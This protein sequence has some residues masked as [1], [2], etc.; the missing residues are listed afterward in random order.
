MVCNSAV[1]GLAPFSA[2][3]DV[4]WFFVALFWYCSECLAAFLCATHIFGVLFVSFHGMKAMTTDGMGKR[5]IYPSTNLELW[6]RGSTLEEH[7]GTD[8]QRIHISNNWNVSRLSRTLKAEMRF[9]LHEHYALLEF[10]LH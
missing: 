5:I 8:S 10:M 6:D 4:V 7:F 1:F 2:Y 3:N 9:T